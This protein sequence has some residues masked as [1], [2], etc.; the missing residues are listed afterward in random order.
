VLQRLAAMDLDPRQLPPDGSSG[1]I[2]AIKNPCEEALSPA[3]AD[4]AH[5]R[6]GLRSRCRGRSAT[7][8]PTPG[9]AAISNLLAPE[10]AVHIT[11]ICPAADHF[12]KCQPR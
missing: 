6:P 4:N 5:Q 2:A 11:T 7:F 8:R 10:N 1:F 12:G 3:S 9:Q